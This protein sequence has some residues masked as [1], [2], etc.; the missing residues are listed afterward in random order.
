MK[1]FY[2]LE[3]LEGTCYIEILPGRYKGNCWNK[4]SIFFEEE[5]FGYL[6]RG[7]EMEFSK[8]DH[9]AFNEIP[10]KFGKRFL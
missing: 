1:I 2:K 10:K 3:E 9:F 6:E 4:E 5:T 7:I 8:Y